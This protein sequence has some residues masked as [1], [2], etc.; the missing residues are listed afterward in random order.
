MVVVAEFFGASSGL[1]QKIAETAQ[2]YETPELYAWVFYTSLLA[3]LL[4]WGADY[5]ERWAM[6]W[7]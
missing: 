1:V 3:L 7:A 2:L 6:R 4:V 5:F